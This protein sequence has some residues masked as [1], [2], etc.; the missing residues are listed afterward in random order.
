M[1][2]LFE[3]LRQRVLNLNASVREEILKTYIAYKLET[4]FVDVIPYKSKLLLTL[5]VN[6]DEIDDPQEFCRDISAVNHWGN[7]NVELS[8]TSMDDIDT[9]MYLVEQA[10]ERQLDEV[11]IV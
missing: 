6:I 7:G 9:V 4:N 1:L 2:I 8:F 11:G 3:A 5:N 10:M